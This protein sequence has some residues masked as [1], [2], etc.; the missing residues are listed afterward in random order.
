[1]QHPY[2]TAEWTADEWLQAWHIGV[3]RVY[4]CAQCGNMIMV[5]KGGTGTLEP[6][7]HGEPMAAVEK[8][9]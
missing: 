5:I 3:G 1:M 7:C 4:R 9:R 6:K 2:S 8:K